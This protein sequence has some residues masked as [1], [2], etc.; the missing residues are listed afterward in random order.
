MCQQPVA[1][2]TA[3]QFI[4]MLPIHIAGMCVVFIQ[5]NKMFNRNHIAAKKRHMD[6][7]K[8]LTGG[9]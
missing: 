3:I 2:F 1:I 5:A 7:V 4:A 8:R 9:K 6:R